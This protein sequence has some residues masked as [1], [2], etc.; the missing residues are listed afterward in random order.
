[1]VIELII[2]DAYLSDNYIL[3]E[4]TMKS[5]V[6][7]EYEKPCLIYASAYAFPNSVTI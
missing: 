4:T 1:M 2:G 6:C 7:K 3:S 5:I